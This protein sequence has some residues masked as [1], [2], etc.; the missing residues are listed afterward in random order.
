MDR[1]IRWISELNLWS[2][3][4]MMVYILFTGETAFLLNALTENIGRFLVTLPARTLQTFAYEPGGAEWMGGWTLF[5][6]AFW[7]AWGPFVGVFL[8]RT[9]RGRTLRE[10][11]IAAITAPVLCDFIIVSLFGNTRR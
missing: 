5:F 10:F 1:G 11:V 8:A 2:A 9:S 4:A 7:L 3:V 6:W